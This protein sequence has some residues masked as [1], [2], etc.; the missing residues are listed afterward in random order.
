MMIDHRIEVLRPRAGDTIVVHIDANNLS[1]EQRD[2]IRAAVQPLLP[3][4]VKA[5]I[6]A[7]DVTLTHIAAVN[8]EAELAPEPIHFDAWMRDR[9]ERA[10][11]EFIERT[12]RRLP[13]DASTREVAAY[14]RGSK[15]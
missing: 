11:R 12:S 6:V 1:I 9:V 15:A 8:T 3:A 5:M 7:R 4:G 13:C 14:M 10:H 2:R